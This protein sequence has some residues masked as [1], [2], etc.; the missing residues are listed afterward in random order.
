MKT[1]D[2]ELKGR[3]HFRI[4]TFLNFF[5]SEILK[6]LLP[7]S[8]I[9]TPQIL[10]LRI[11]IIYLIVLYCILVIKYQFIPYIV[12]C[13][14]IYV[15]IYLTNVVQNLCTGYIYTEQINSTAQIKSWN[16][17]FGSNSSWFFEVF[18]VACSKLKLKSN[19]DKGLF[20]RLF[21]IGN[22]SEKCLRIQSAF[23]PVLSI[24]SVFQQQNIHSVTSRHLH[25]RPLFRDYTPF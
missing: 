8:K 5:V 18:L 14:L 1:K 17:S 21:W 16:F 13:E 10:Y 12:F 9:W 19:V 25:Q 23:N 22:S 2:S 11:N 24:C 6:L 15:L 4:Q 20:F 7:L 3:N